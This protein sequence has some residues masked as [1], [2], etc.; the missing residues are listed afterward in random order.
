MKEIR[1]RTEASDNATANAPGRHTLPLHLPVSPLE[2]HKPNNLS[3]VMPKAKIEPGPS[4]TRN[5]GHRAKQ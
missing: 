5:L 4:Q 3:S 1:K 2:L